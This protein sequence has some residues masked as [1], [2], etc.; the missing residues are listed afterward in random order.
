MNFEKIAAQIPSLQINMPRFLYVY[1]WLIYKIPEFFD[2]SMIEL[3]G[4][5]HSSCTWLPNVVTEKIIT[6]EAVYVKLA[7]SLTTELAIH[8]L[9]GLFTRLFHFMRLTWANDSHTGPCSPARASTRLPRNIVTMK[10][11]D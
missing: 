1:G 5:Q 10:G 4:Q 8:Y 2:I 7:T 9:T 11:F 6:R 3:A